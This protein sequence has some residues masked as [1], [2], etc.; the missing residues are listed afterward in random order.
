MSK[1]PTFACCPRCNGRVSALSSSSSGPLLRLQYRGVMFHLP[2]PHESVVKHVA[3]VFGMRP[4]GVK[5]LYK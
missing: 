5:L 2:E 3:E 1:Q 4:S